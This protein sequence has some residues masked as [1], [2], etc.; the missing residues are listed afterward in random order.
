MNHSSINSAGIDVSKAMLDIA[1]CASEEAFRE[2]NDEAGHGRLVGRLREAGIT[3]VGIEASGGYEEALK[4]VLIKKGFEVV[5]FDPRQIHGYRTFRNKRAKTDAIDA[6]LIAAVTAAFDGERAPSDPRLPALA[7]HLLMVDQ[8]GEDIAQLKTRRERYHEKANLKFIAGEIK[9][10]EKLRGKQLQR[11]VERV[12]GH[13]DLARAMTLLQS[14]PGL[15][16][17]AALNF[18]IRM[19]ELGKTSRGEAAA[20]VGVAPFNFD[21]GKMA[22]ERHIAGGRARLRKAVYMSA[23][24][25]SQRWNPLLVALYKRLIAKGKHHKPATV[26][27]ARKLVEI[28][29]ATLARGTPW[30]HRSPLALET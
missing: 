3:R 4:R 23:F 7:E 21:T 15:G 13:A 6:K 14:I 12:C 8:L 9:R 26:A 1:Y 18:V 30:Q 11:L 27:C 29:N 2:A 10:L 17:M 24:A 22:G 25:A 16:Q 20:L 5:V 19:P 28:A